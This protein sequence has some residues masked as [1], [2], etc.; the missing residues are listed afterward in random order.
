[1]SDYREEII[2]RNISVVFSHKGNTITAVKD[3]SFDIRK[4]EV[5]GIVGTSGAGK[6]TLLRTINLLQKPT[7]GQVV[8]NGN[9]ITVLKGEALRKFRTNI[10]MIF[11]QF[12]LIN[13]KNVYDNVAFVMKA[14]G[15]TKQEISSRVPEVL[16]LVGLSD[17]SSAYPAKLSGGEKQRVGIARA[18]ANNPSI[19]LCD[20]PTSALDLE[21]TSGILK[22]IKEINQKTSITTVIISHEM[23]VI[24]KICNRVAVMHQ[25]EIVELDDAFRVFSSPE[26]EY[27][28]S[29]INYSLDLEMPLQSFNGKDFKTV[30][31]LYSDD[32]ADEAVISDTIEKFHITINIRLGKIEYITNKPFGVLIV[33]LVGTADKILA[34]EEY[35]RSRTYKVIEIN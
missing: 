11:Q 32:R 28:K 1:M 25:G 17:R 34:A 26:H 27:T 3:V 15:K 30:K 16:E 33:Q 13:S 29:L 7:R 9:D 6:S 10:G 18:L 31:I 19:L 8:I 2:F 23:N 5:F 24:K 20:E 21:N 4:G 22:L 14:I 12:N 35:I